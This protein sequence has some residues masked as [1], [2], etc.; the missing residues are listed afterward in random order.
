MAPPVGA[1]GAT[2]IFE[3]TVLDVGGLQ[4]SQT[5]NVHV[6]DNGI[7]GSGSVRKEEN[8]TLEM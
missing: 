3:L 7:T 2:L 5:V 4:S 1:G 6:V 8:G